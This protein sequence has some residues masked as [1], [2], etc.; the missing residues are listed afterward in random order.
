MH[1]VSAFGSLCYICNLQ[2]AGCIGHVY[3][4][5]L[6]RQLL[7]KFAPPQILLFRQVPRLL[8]EQSLGCDC[9]PRRNKSGDAWWYLPPISCV[10]D[11]SA[12]SRLFCVSKC[13]ITT[14]HAL[15]PLNRQLADYA[16]L[17]EAVH[18]PSAVGAPSRKR[19]PSQRRWLFRWRRQNQQKCSRGFSRPI[20]TPDS[21]R[22]S[23]VRVRVRLTIPNTMTIFSPGTRRT[24]TSRRSCFTPRE[25]EAAAATPQ[26]THCC[27]HACFD[28]RPICERAVFFSFWHA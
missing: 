8:H 11:E 6:P 20:A 19:A 18:L 2:T 25:K 15:N 28:Q 24:S 26:Q 13:Q 4:V 12:D 16:V 17:C 7:H 27:E 3:R 14:K 23:D 22:P 21:F 10:G 1:C 9:C 5:S